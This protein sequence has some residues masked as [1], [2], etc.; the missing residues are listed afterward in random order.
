MALSKNLLYFSSSDSRMF[1]ALVWSKFRRSPTFWRDA[2][3]VDVGGRRRLHQCEHPR[4]GRPEEKSQARAGRHDRSDDAVPHNA[5]SMLPVPE[6]RSRTRSLRPRYG[7]GNRSFLRLSIHLQ[8]GRML[9]F[10]QMP[11][12]RRGAGSVSPSDTET[13]GT[14]LQMLLRHVS[15]SYT[16]ELSREGGSLG[17][18]ARSDPAHSPPHPRRASP[19]AR[20]AR[21]VPSSIEA[22]SRSAGAIRMLERCVAGRRRGANGRAVSVSGQSCGAF[23]QRVEFR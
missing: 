6:H 4:W 19:A 2:A 20:Q 14:M 5:R 22:A 9:A 17:E 1:C 11:R 18:W 16:P 13:E 10:G 12:P 8:H 21:R 3:G 15:E 23:A 7:G